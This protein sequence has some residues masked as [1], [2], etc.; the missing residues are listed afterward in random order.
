MSVW[1]WLGLTSDPAQDAANTAADRKVAAGKSAAIALENYRQN[2]RDQYH[3]LL[4]QRMA[5]YQA[6][7]NRLAALTGTG[8]STA[9]LS[10][11]ENPLSLR[12]TGVGAPVGSNYAGWTDTDPTTGQQVM[13]QGIGAYLNGTALPEH[14]GIAPP[15]DQRTIDQRASGMMFGQDPRGHY[16]AN[17][18]QYH[19]DPAIVNADPYHVAESQDVTQN[20]TYSASSA[21]L[22]PGGGSYSPGAGI[23]FMPRRAP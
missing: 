22:T 3:N 12:D 20:P 17:G 21:A 19:Q 6:Y 1:S 11:S 2:A 15:P 14:R 7:S 13:H 10:A 5:P 23:Q 18:V 16:G 9:G 8:M 4:T